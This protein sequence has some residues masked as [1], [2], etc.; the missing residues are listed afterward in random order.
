MNNW[1]MRQG[2][3]SVIFSHTEPKGSQHG[4]TE[5]AER[6]LVVIYIFLYYDLKYYFRR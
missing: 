1:G 2:E 6:E 5:D 3:Y 4:G